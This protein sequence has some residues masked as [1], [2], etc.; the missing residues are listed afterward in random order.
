MSTTYRIARVLY[1]GV[2]AGLAAQSP[3]LVKE[4][5]ETGEL[6]KFREGLYEGVSVARGRNRLSIASG[7]DSCPVRSKERTSTHSSTVGWRLPT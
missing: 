2:A 3:G 5:V 4:V 7:S 1:K 6:P